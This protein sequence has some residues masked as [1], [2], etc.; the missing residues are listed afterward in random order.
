ML[1]DSISKLALATVALLAER[2]EALRQP[3]KSGS[4]SQPLDW[5]NL[6]PV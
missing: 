1:V 2:R 4:K 3:F 6:T 5:K